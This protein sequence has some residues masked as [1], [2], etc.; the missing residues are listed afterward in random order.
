MKIF[1]TGASGYIGG[2]VAAV[3]RE[4]GH[5]I[6]GL[7]RSSKR[8]NQLRMEGITPVLGALEDSRVLAEAAV[9]A[10]AVINCADSDHRGAV[11]VMLQ[12]MEDTDKPFLHTSGTSIVGYPDQGEERD[13]IF[14]EEMPFTPSPGRIER[15]SINEEVVKAAN[16][17]IRTVVLCP[18]LIYG[19]GLGIS[20]DSMQVP[21]LLTVA[22]KFGTAKHIGP[23][24]NLWSNVH[25]QDLTDL[26]CL[27]LKEAPSGSF[28]FAENGENSMREVCESINTMMG[29]N[30]PPLSM[31]IAEASVEWGESPANHTM[32]SNSRVRA[33]R[34]R[35]ELGWDPRAGS[36]INE[37]KYGCYSRH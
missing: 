9:N 4:A 31:T 3:L 16:R 35:L 15:V 18:S 29:V 8:A 12:A 36:L 23:G 28:Y 24:G 33:K 37:I 5:E 1:I 10:D 6:S 17:G 11:E 34:A 22:D 32:G 13:S 7:A 14:D 27:A 21:W 20:K 2:S 30:S 25:I 19:E 26:Y